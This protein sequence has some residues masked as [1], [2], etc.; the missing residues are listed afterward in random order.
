VN[1]G[2]IGC[3]S[4]AET[5]HLP[6]YQNAPGVR[7]VSLADPDGTRLN[8]LSH[9]FRVKNS[10][11]DYH[12]LLR[13]QSIDAVSVCVP[14]AFH[15]DVV[16]DAASSGKDI[17]CEKPLARTA[18]EAK[19]MLAVHR[20]YGVE[21]YVGFSS[22]F[23]RV[24]REVVNLVNRGFIKIPL[25]VHVGLAAPRPSIGSWY[26]KREMGGGCLFD[27]GAHGVDLLCHY[28]GEGRV[29]SASFECP[30]GVDADIAASVSMEIG[31]D[32]KASL[33]ADWRSQHFERILKIRGENGFMLADS[34]ASVVN[35]SQPKVT[36]GKRV[37]QFTLRFEQ[38]ISEYWNEVWE[39]VDSVRS[40]KT[41]SE[42]ANG[43]DGL[44][45]LRVVEEAYRHLSE[46]KGDTHG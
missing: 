37:G 13:N 41:S 25:D 11:M 36:L 44:R 20:K 9:K 34:M 31:T 17:L 21:L 24:V 38:R 40:N 42:L 8:L 14:T 12:D 29:S 46:R 7:I 3:G 10:F 19:D 45:A 32:V 26:L 5:V 27:M 22:R 30:S 43:E 16:L 28:F 2:I 18:E 6:A 35:V 4:I 23:S 1:V 15:H 33:Q 39:F